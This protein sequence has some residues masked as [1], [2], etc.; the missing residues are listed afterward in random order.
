MHVFAGLGL[1]TS[2]CSSACFR[3]SSSCRSCSTA[4]W[5]A[6]SLT[7]RWFSSS[8]FSA[9]VVRMACCCSECHFS[10]SALLDDSSSSN[11][12]CEL[13]VRPAR[14]P[15]LTQQM[16]EHARAAEKP[17]GHLTHPSFH[18]KETR[19]TKWLR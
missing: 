10:S 17:G 15:P 6:C 11:L 19:F 18:K 7:A 8:C 13:G 9:S 4:S 5:S 14:S 2:Y 16:T 3:S 1:M 12:R